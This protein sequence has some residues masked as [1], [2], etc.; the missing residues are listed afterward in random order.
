MTRMSEETLKATVQRDLTTAMRERDQVRAGTLRMALTAITTEEVA[1]KEARELSDDD[2]L[3]VIAKEAK[4][5]KEAATA[6]TDAG[7]PELAAKEVAELAILEDYLPAQLSDEELA[8]IAARAV[9]QAGASGMAQMGQV[10][11]AAQ[12]EVAGRADGG[13]VAAAVKAALSAR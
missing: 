7:R 9:E 5:R 13:R 10:M 4:K 1:G 6:F 3:R 11:K 12:A 8:S 2:V